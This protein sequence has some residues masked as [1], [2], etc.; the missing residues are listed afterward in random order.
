[1]NYSQ[2]MNERTDKQTSGEKTKKDKEDK[3][4]T[5]AM[6]QGQRVQSED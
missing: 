1:M 6:G 2:R 4:R 5:H 3:R